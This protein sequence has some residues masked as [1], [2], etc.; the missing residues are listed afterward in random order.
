MLVF[1]AYTP[2]QH[3]CMRPELYS[4][5]GVYIRPLL[6]RGKFAMNWRVESSP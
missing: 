4:Q 6:Y 1:K 2:V 5:Q 3:T